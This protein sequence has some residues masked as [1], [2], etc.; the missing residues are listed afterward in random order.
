MTTL[1]DL[2]PGDWVTVYGDVE[3]EILR[4]EDRT[5]ADDDQKWVSVRY[6]AVASGLVGTF[7]WPASVTLP[8]PVG[9]D[10]PP[11]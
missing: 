1:A 7:V 10:G 3:A 9:S 5:Y 6:R 8:L 4:V 2:K 11:E